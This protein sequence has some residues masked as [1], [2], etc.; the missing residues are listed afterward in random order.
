MSSAKGHAE[1]YEDMLKRVSELE[2]VPR[3]PAVL[4]AIVKGLFPGGR[5]SELKPL[6]TG[7]CSDGFTPLDLRELVERAAESD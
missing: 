4:D 1:F 2:P 5:A 6:R 7:E 3:D